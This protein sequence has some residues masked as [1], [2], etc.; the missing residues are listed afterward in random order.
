MAHPRYFVRHILELAADQDFIRGAQVGAPV[1]V[2]FLIRHLT[3]GILRIQH[4]HHTV[5][6]SHLPCRQTSPGG[7][8][9]GSADLVKRHLVLRR[10]GLDAGDARD[11]LELEGANT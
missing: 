7:D 4:H 1:N 3:V 6:L 10:Q 5:G 8:L 9:N 2:S 11:H